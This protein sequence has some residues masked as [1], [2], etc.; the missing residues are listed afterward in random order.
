[1]LRISLLVMAILSTG[2]ARAEDRPLEID[3]QAMEIAQTALGFLEAQQV[4][5]FQWFITYDR[6]FEGREKI[7][8]VRSGSSL[9]ARGQGSRSYLETGNREREYIHD[10]KTLTISA[11]VQG[12]YS[13]APIEGSFDTA[14][15]TAREQAGLVLPVWQ[16]MSASAR[17]FLAEVEAARYLGV[18]RVNG[19]EAHH[20]A[21]SEY[22]RDFQMW[23]STDAERPLPL[24]VVGTDP[25]TQGWP[26]YHAFFYDWDLA[27]EI[28]PDAFTFTPANGAA[29]IGFSTLSADPSSGTL[30]PASE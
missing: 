8:F 3:P 14:V 19:Q 25:Y 28:G 7:T 18:T 12:F 29:K 22:D 5:S 1:M 24:M 16:I 2:L 17:D 15:E 13:Q 26:Q 30:Q 20:L 23:I 4:M 11:P 9:L 6:I 10:G 21:F 27:P